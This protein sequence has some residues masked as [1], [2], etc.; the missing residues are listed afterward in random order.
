MNTGDKTFGLGDK[1]KELDNLHGITKEI[2]NKYHAWLK[3]RGLVEEQRKTTKS[4]K[5]GFPRMMINNTIDLPTNIELEELEG[6]GQ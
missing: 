5:R 4:G 1:D 2:H 6:N 3:R